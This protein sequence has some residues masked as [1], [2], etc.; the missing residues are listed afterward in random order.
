MYNEKYN[1]EGRGEILEEKG[2]YVYLKC[3]VLGKRC[4]ILKDRLEKMK[5][6]YPDFVERYVS[7]EGKN[8]LKENLRNENSSGRND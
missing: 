3:A 5:Q 7:N 2:K 4:L 8:Q 1:F 6:K